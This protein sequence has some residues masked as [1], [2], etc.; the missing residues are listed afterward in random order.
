[1]RRTRLTV[2]AVC[3][4]GALAAAPANVVAHGTS[5]HL[6]GTVHGASFPFLGSR[7]TIYRVWASPAGLCGIARRWVP[8]LTYERGGNPNPF[9]LPHAPAG[10]ECI[11]QPNSLHV[12]EMGMCIT[13]A[14]TTFNWSVGP[15]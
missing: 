11:S 7:T 14:R 5:N 6:C 10:F 15:F 3:A 2:L 4:L 12:S 8:R 13:K 9:R 1:M